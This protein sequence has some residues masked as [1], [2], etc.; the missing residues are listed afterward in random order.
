MRQP[1]Q[2][3]ALIRVEDE[4]GEALTLPS[5][6]AYPAGSR[7]KVE[8]LDTKTGKQDTGVGA[9]RATR[10]YGNAA[11]QAALKAVEEIKRVAA[12]QMKTS[13]D[14]LTLAKGG[15]QPKRGGKRCLRLIGLR[16]SPDQIRK[17]RRQQF[18][19]CAL[20]RLPFCI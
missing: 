20:A 13:S 5:G 15:V 8:T 9:S 7:I 17:K 3:K 19:S 14:Q 12:E 10:V 18:Q 16:S 4:R 11:Y 1:R 2:A 6:S